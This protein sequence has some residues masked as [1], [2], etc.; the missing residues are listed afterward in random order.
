MTTKATQVCEHTGEFVGMTQV[1]T[2]AVPGKPPIIIGLTT[3]GI[4]LVYNWDTRKWI[5]LDSVDA[6]KSF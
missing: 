6:T 5:A 2:V 3:S 1:S 4:L